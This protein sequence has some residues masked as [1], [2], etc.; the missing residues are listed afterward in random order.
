LG[1]AICPDVVSGL[2]EADERGVGYSRP[3]I[4]KSSRPSSRPFLSRYSRML[5]LS[6]NSRIP[7][8]VRHARRSLERPSRRRA[9]PAGGISRL[10]LAGRPRRLKKPLS[11]HSRIPWIVWHARRSPGGRRAGAPRARLLLACR[12]IQGIPAERARRLA[13]PW[14]VGWREQECRE[15]AKSSLIPPRRGAARPPP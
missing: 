15:T 5:P 6:R 11:R 13:K 8:I 14:R 2:P 3:R 1:G 10:L 4:A 7:W 9:E 12:T